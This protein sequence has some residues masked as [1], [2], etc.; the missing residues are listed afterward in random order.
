[1]QFQNA[2]ISVISLISMGFSCLKIDKTFPYVF[3]LSTTF[4]SSCNIPSLQQE[5]QE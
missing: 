1:M 4:F 3:F 5:N 2:C